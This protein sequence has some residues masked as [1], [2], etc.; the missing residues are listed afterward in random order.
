MGYKMS[1]NLLLYEALRR[2]RS[3]KFFTPD[4]QSEEDIE[5]FQPVAKAIIHA[6][7]NG[8]IQKILPSQISMGGQL[9]YNGIY[10]ISGLSFKGESLLK[11]FAGEPTPADNNLNELIVKLSSHSIKE[12]WNKALHRRKEDPAGAITSARSTMEAALKWIIEQRGAS[13]TDSNKELFKQTIKV[14]GIETQ[15]KPIEKLLEGLDLILRGIGEMRNKHGDAHGPASSSPTV[16][17][18]EAGL[19]VNLSSAVILYFLE[20]FEQVKIKNSDF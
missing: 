20:E 1:M 13:P 10:V 7:E 9:Y 6:S 19:C 11:E 16:S 17:D 2:A 3:E 8:Y 12:N 5:N 18:N 15:G 4:S 14:L